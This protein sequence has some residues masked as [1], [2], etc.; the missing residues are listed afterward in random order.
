V[1]AFTFQLTDHFTAGCDPTDVVTDDK[2]GQFGSPKRLPS[3]GTKRSRQIDH[4][5]LMASH[6]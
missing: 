5:D 3:G 1:T 6:G 2:C 4:G